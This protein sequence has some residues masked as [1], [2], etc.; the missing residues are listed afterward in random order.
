MKSLAEFYHHGEDIE[1][2]DDEA[3]RLMQEAANMGYG[4]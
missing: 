3:L 2:D 4:P 1:K